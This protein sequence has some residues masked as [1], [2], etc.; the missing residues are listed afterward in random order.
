MHTKVCLKTPAIM[1][2]PGIP[3]C[4][5]SSRRS[6]SSA[7][8]GLRTVHSSCR[9]DR[10]WPRGVRVA[11][12]CRLR[13]CRWANRMEAGLDCIIDLSRYVPLILRLLLHI[14]PS[15]QV[16][17]FVLCKHPGYILRKTPFSGKRNIA[18][19]KKILISSSHRHNSVNSVSRSKGIKKR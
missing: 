15:V 1:W 12:I 9:P 10:R 16:I 11:R 6:S 3:T 7:R 4:A 8:F 14:W 13:D 2:W 17:H 5:A 19:T 18:K